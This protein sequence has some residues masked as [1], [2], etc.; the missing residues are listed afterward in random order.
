MKKALPLTFLTL[1]AIKF[2][3][4]AQ[5]TELGKIQSSLG[6]IKDSV[7]YVDALNRMAMLLYEKNIDST[8]FYTVKAR[9]TADR[10][11]YE[12]GKAD[13]TNNLGVFFDIKGNLQLALRYYNDAYI[14]YTKVKDSSNQVQAMMNIAMVYKELG[15]DQRAISHYNNA[16][17]F[18]KKLSKDSILSLTIYNYLL[19]FPNQFKKA[20][21]QA[22]VGQAGRIAQKYKDS[23]TMLAIEQLIADD[24]IA[25][26]QRATGLTMLAKTIDSALAKQL[27]FVSMDLIMAIGDQLAET[28]ASQ[29]IGHYNK[30]LEIA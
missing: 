21:K 27:Y 1:L 23:R 26:G 18:G 28:D 6:K 15:K 29:A 25:S 2:C 9:A 3:C 12:K 4:W 8:F 17:E 19:Q 30:G 5:T 22:M 7:Q 20:E 14:G 13:A 11:G 10:L 24:L 16:L